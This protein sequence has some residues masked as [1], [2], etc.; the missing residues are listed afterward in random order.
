MRKR[1]FSFKMPH[2]YALL[3]FI[4]ILVSIST[5]FIPAGEF[6]RI[7]SESG[8]IIVDP[9]SYHFVD[10]NPY[11]PFDVFKAVPKGMNA[12]GYLIF[13]TL[14]ISGAF[15][16]LRSTGAI[17]A[18]IMSIVK[19]MQGR[20]VYTIPV[21][22][23]IFSLAGAILGS[24]EE[25]LPFYP[26]IISLALAL[27]F[28]SVTGVA[29][30][31]LGS[32]AGFAG[33]MLNPFTVGVAQ[34][35]AGLPLYSGIFFRFIAYLILLAVAILHVSKYATKVQKNKEFSVIY[36]DEVTLDGNIN[37]NEIGSLNLKHKLVLF[38]FLIGLIVLAY[39]VSKLD[40]YIT[41]LAALFLIIGI[42]T[43]LVGGLPINKIAEEFVN[44]MQEMVY[45]ALIIG[46][47]TGIMVV[48]QETKI[49]D[50]VIYALANL[51]V[52]LPSVF[53]GVGMFLVQSLI[54]FF[55]PSGSGQAAASMPIMA[56]MA[57]IIGITR[58]S[59]VLAF[60]FGDAFSNVINPTSGYF[61]AGIAIGGIKWEKWVK[62]MLPLF[63]IWTLIGAILVAIS[64]AINYGP[65]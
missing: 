9:E 34:G 56:P 4:I 46:L 59:A 53:A 52:G 33:A 39:G 18:G 21:I 51:V 43:G 2:T 62:F 36:G 55:I 25:M 57:D 26:I 38:L 58:Q 6:N 42:V 63:I 49:I 32:G 28:D 30:V 31:M 8:R 47:A 65:F 37:F 41:E 11:T 60:Q 20:E 48:M 24:A 27:G 45:G 29:M 35:I 17:D 40:F 23:F 10:S 16:I 12:N 54:N 13:F 15:R 22:M 61:M 7:E 3:F 64:V 14:I 44:G 5:H 1:K 50:T 19:Q